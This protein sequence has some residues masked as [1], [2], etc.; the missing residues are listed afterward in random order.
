MNYRFLLFIGAATVLVVGGKKGVA[1]TLS[2]LRYYCSYSTFPM[3]STSRRRG[4]FA[5]CLQLY[6]NTM[7]FVAVTIK[8][9]AGPDI[10]TTGCGATTAICSFKPLH[11]ENSTV[12]TCVNSNASSWT[13][14]ANDSMTATNNLA[15]WAN[16]LN[17][18]FNSGEFFWKELDYT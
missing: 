3:A 7:K 6:L 2:L 15:I 18:L 8:N 12:C 1:F 4:I 11:N 5:N 17:R 13:D 16:P 9:A 10:V 14:E